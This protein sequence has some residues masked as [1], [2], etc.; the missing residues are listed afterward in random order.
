ML[1]VGVRLHAGGRIP[2]TFVSID[3]I[4]FQ[5]QFRRPEP[6]DA[7]GQHLMMTA[8]GPRVKK[9]RRAWGCAPDLPSASDEPARSVMSAPGP[10]TPPSW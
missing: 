2:G 5:H 8:R 4:K 7:T 1:A 10:P 3:D 6:R 9:V